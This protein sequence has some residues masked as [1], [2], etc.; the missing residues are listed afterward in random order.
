[1]RIARRLPVIVLLLFTACWLIGCTPP[2]NAYRR[3]YGPGPWDWEV[4]NND[5]IADEGLVD[6][7]SLYARYGYGYDYRR[8]YKDA[9][10]DIGRPDPGLTIEP[11]EQQRYLD[12]IPDVPTVIE[13][14]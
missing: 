10:M 9:R 14:R 4:Q 2:A 3:V 12:M 7:S 11:A 6:P 5:R 8:A 1:M 13:P